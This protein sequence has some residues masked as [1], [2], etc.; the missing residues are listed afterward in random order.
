MESDDEMD[1]FE[2]SLGSLFGET[3]FAHG[4]TRK[5][6]PYEISNTEV[7]VKDN[8]L[9]LKLPDV[10]GGE[11]YLMSH[12][13][14][15]SSLLMAKQIE[16]NIIN[17]KGKKVLELGAGAGLPSLISC[18]NNAKE[19]VVSDYPDDII[20]KNL[21]FNKKKNIPENLA[22]KITVVGHA[23]GKNIEQLKSTGKEFEPFDIILCSDTLWMPD[24]HHS[25]LET[26]SKCLSHH[27]EDNSVPP[28]VY[29]FCGIH[30]GFITV[31][32][33]FRKSESMGFKWDLENVY[34]I[35]EDSFKPVNKEIVENIAEDDMSERKK[36]IL[37]YILQWK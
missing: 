27:Q 32:H 31:D 25:L 37:K 26:L 8:T 22:N 29:F 30:T 13:I 18:L 6:F 20:V 14:W 15:N 35:V 28:T 34:K 19:V 24:Q 11:V 36:Y 12:Y 21:E 2:D 16:N 7:K 4:D 23:W 3:K 9:Y 33:F 17:V 1:I 5:L 10:N